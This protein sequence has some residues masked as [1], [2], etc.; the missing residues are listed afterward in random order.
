MGLYVLTTLFF[1]K[2][3]VSLSIGLCEIYKTTPYVICVYCLPF[4]R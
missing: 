3:K 1:N 2:F 4:Y